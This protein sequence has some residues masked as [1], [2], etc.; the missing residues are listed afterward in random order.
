MTVDMSR[1]DTCL[2]EAEFDDLARGALAP[3]ALERL[4]A[5]VQAVL[6]DPSDG[7]S[8]DEVWSRLEH[9]MKRAAR[10]A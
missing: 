1:P 6:D 2:S 7:V 4:R 9:R 3:S 10:A 5:R 8:H